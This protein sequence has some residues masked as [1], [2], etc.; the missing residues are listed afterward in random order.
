[1][2]E[3]GFGLALEPCKRTNLVQIF[4][5]IVSKQKYIEKKEKLKF[6]AAYKHTYGLAVRAVSG[7]GIHK[8]QTSLGL[9]EVLNDC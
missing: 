9:L 6:V 8:K 3:E 4:I 1:M 2:G 7:E 5:C